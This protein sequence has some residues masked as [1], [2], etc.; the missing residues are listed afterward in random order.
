VDSPIEARD[1]YEEDSG[2]TLADI[3]QLLESEQAREQRRSLPRQAGKPMLAELSTLE[4]V[5]VKHFAVLALQKSPLKDQFDLDEILELIEV[6][7]STFWN[8]F[9]R[10]NE[11]KNMKKKGS[12]LRCYSSQCHG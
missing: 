12:P 5:I 8:R 3:P 10:G 2:L 11:K 6:K 1:S 4:L 7:K 9:F